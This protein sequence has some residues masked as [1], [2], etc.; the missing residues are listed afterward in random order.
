MHS[1][2]TAEHF[3]KEAIMERI[4]KRYYWPSIYPDIIQYI[5]NC[6]TC[7]KKKGIKLSKPLKPIKSQEKQKE[8]HDNQ[9]LD[10]PIKFR[11]EDKVLLHRT[12]AEKQWSGKFDPKWDKLF[13][14][15]EI[16]G[17][18]AYKLRLNNKI[19]TKAAHGDRL[20]SYQN[21]ILA[22]TSN[23]LQLGAQ[24]ILVQPDEIPQDLEPII[25]IEPN[26]SN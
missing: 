19:L 2:L 26:M 7:Q 17:N 21:I 23:I 6:D 10:K 8:R 3:H 25:I 9:L 22:S 24:R 11:I 20:K 1:D 5:Q 12:K 15:E 16:L 14:I 13:Y 18:G 4:R